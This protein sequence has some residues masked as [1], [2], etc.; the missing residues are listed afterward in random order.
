MAR[1]ADFGSNDRT[2]FAKTHLGNLLHPGDHAVGYDVANANLADPELEKAL[3]KV[4]EVLGRSL[5]GGWRG[6]VGVPVAGVW[7]NAGAVSGACCWH[8]PLLLVP[9]HAC[10]A[11]P[12]PASFNGAG[13]D[14]A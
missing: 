13:S 4:G 12:C 9:S 7:G 3:H 2:F 1:A 11:L 5:G 8:Q 6:W 10:P 14:A